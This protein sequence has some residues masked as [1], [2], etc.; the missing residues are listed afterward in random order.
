MQLLFLRLQINLKAIFKHESET[1]LVTKIQLKLCQHPRIQLVRSISYVIVLVGL[2]F[3]STHVE[4]IHTDGLSFVEG[5]ARW[6]SN[7]RKSLVL[8]KH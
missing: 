3:R 2:W 8:R 7:Q 4:L 5:A 6:E 1:V